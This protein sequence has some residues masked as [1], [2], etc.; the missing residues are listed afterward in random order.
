M[1]IRLYWSVQKSCII[2]KCLPIEN[3]GVGSA[4]AE[5]ELPRLLPA[6]HDADSESRDRRGNISIPFSSSLQLGYG[7]QASLPPKASVR[8]QAS[9]KS[10]RQG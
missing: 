2:Q 1:K 5:E 8:H 4:L 3:L 7:K 10:T 6:V 9:N